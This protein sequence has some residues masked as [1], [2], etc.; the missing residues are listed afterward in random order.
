MR[1]RPG[2]GRSAAHGP[3]AQRVEDVVWC[4]VAWRGSSACMHALRACKHA[5]TDACT[6]ASLVHA[7]L[8]LLVQRIATHDPFGLLRAGLHCTQRAALQLQRVRVRALCQPPHL[9]AFTLRVWLIL[10]GGSRWK[11]CVIECVI[12]LGCGVAAHHT[13]TDCVS[14][15][16]RV[17]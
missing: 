13:T 8:I 3:V 1:A 9:P 14:T 16:G 4:G 12:A 2:P 7:H 10:A 6:R 15:R 5:H 11:E 17:E